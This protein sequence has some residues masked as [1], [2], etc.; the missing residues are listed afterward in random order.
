MPVLMP[1]STLNPLK[2]ATGVS[3]V[4]YT[5]DF[6]GLYKRI[7]NLEKKFKTGKGPDEFIRYIP[8]LA[9]P[10]YQGQIS[11]MQERRLSLT[12]RIKISG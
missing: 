10:T 11:G 2:D 3:A 8:G 12:I 9:K 1:S 5:E 6:D 4:D 7:D